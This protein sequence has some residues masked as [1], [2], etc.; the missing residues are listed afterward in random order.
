MRT[1]KATTISPVHRLAI[2][3]LAIN[4]MVPEDSQIFVEGTE[5]VGGRYYPTTELMRL[6]RA[7]YPG[8]RFKVLLGN[9]LL[10]SLHLWDDFP[11]LIAENKFMV[12][13]RIYSTSSLGNTDEDDIVTLCDSN[14]TRLSIER[15]RN[16]FGFTPIISNIS[17]T[18]VRK[19]M[20]MEGLRA[21]VGLT[22]LVV[23]EYIK[24]QKLYS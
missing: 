21:I 11:D 4:A 6:Y 12:Y 16:S 3:T 5:V 20:R 14:H 2:V 19:R 15:I 8:L 13:T 10:P 22:P 9:D 17:S 24:Q 7:R 18:E 23:Y 1:D